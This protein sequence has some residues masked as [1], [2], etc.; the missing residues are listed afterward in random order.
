VTRILLDVDGVIADLV[1]DLCSELRAVG[2]RRQPEDVTTYEFQ[3][4]LPRD[5]LAV[6][7][8]AMVRPG[9]VA[10]MSWYPGAREFVRELQRLG[11]VVAV[12]KPFATSPTWAYERAVWLGRNIEKV[13]Q[14][15]HK[16]LVGGDFLIED[17]VA[18]AHTWRHAHPGGHAILLQ[19]PWC[20]VHRLDMPLMGATSYEAVLETIRCL[21]A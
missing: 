7:R 2:Y 17:C 8:G 10:S 12:T 16:E 1:G 4:A 11:E 9:F 20:D 19:R 21:S 13:V 18:N 5:E 3:H 14:T 15:A 6:V